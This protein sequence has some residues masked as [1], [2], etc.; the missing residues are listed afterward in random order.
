MNTIH[1][2]SL[3]HYPVAYPKPQAGRIG[4]SRTPTADAGTRNPSAQRGELN[5][6][7]SSTEL[8]QAALSETGLSS[9]NSS[10]LIKHS[11]TQKALNAYVQNYNQAA[12]S[13]VAEI[14]T[15]ID[16]YA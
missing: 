6:R 4:D 5:T 8:I 1:S 15:G 12:Y 7:P 11:H 2:S 3:T 10:S 9:D 16:T 14:V 13:R